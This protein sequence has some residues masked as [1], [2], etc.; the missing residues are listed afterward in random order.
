MTDSE[1]FRFLGIFYLAVSFGIIIDPGYYRKFL[2]SYCCELTAIFLSG[3]IAMF[4]GYLIITRHNIWQNTPAVIITILGWLAFLKG[5]F[6]I[7]VP[8]AFIRIVEIFLKTEKT[9]YLQAIVGLIIGMIF[10]LIS[11]F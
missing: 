1:I 5:I 10:L 11:C 2:R 4:A 9:V 7:V 3:M 6:I 8:Q